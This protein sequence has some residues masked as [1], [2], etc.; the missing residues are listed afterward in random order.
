MVKQIVNIIQNYKEGKAKLDQKR[1][2]DLQEQE[3]NYNGSHYFHTEIKPAIERNYSHDVA[4]LKKATIQAIENILV[5]VDR[6]LSSILTNVNR[7]ALAEVEGLKGLNLSPYEAQL[8]F[9]KY[10]GNYWAENAFIKAFGDALNANRPQ[11]D[12]LTFTHAEELAAAAN[13]L[14]A[15]VAYII[16]NYQLYPVDDMETAA[17][18]QVALIEQKFDSYIDRLSTDYIIE[19][20]F[21]NPVPL[22]DSENAEVE[23]IFKGCQWDHERRDRARHAVAE[24]KGE[25]VS[26]SDEYKDYLPGDYEPILELSEAGKRLA[27]G[28]I[29]SSQYA[30][31]APVYEQGDLENMS[32]TV[33]NSIATDK[34]E[35]AIEI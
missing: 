17:V 7:E 15:D 26:R 34:N 8:F 18:V 2:D 3:K 25:L 19:P 30:G 20:M 28:E 5:N 29:N 23:R 27:N 22:N 11:E 6:H 16:D 9:D 21:D 12:Q 33:T 4:N 13:E 31:L 24:G 32:V 14:R 10:K 1:H 35:E